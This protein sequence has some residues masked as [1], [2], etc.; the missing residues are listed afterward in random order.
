VR[1]SKSSNPHLQSAVFNACAGARGQALV[2]YAIVFPLQLMMTLAI[3]QLAQIFVAK[4]VLEYA[5]FCGARATLVGLSEQEAQRA[6]CIPLSGVCASSP[7]DATANVIL[8]GW[9]SRTMSTQLYNQLQQSITDESAAVQ[10]GNP[11][12]GSAGAE[13]QAELSAERTQLNNNYN[14][15][16]TQYLSGYGIASDPAITT[17]NFQ[18]VTSTQTP[19]SNLLP[20]VY[21]NITFN[22][23]LLV[24]VG[25]VVDYQIGQLFMG[26]DSQYLTR[27]NNQ[28]CLVMTASCVLP[29]PP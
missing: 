9:G 7:E 24:P 26:V 5:A 19:T 13:I 6:A 12:A 21:C 14:A 1:K 15:P 11:R 23:P 29:Q 10:A 27:V 17:V 22:Y 18:T 3:I 8:P 25:N 4:Q 2:E 28:P 16:P 20:G